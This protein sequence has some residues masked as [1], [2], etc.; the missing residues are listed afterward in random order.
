MNTPNSLRITPGSPGNT[1][2]SLASRDRH[3]FR[4]TL[5]RR[6]PCSQ[7]GVRPVH[8]SDILARGQDQGKQRCKAQ[9]LAS[10]RTPLRT[11][12]TGSI[13]T[14][15]WCVDREAH[16][17]GLLARPQ[18]GQRLQPRAERSYTSWPS[19][20]CFEMNISLPAL[21]ITLS[22]LDHRGG[23]DGAVAMEATEPVLSTSAGQGTHMVCPQLNALSA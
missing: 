6:S 16:R 20:P 9:P 3:P 8:I 19:S 15:D 18:L 4:T 2:R 14:H 13:R 7:R 23:A 21:S 17:R 1:Q 11:P 12:A 5:K 22:C 10:W